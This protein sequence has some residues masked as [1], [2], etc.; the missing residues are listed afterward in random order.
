MKPKAAQITPC[1]LLAELS[2]PSVTQPF[3]D[4]C[5]APMSFITAISVQQIHHDDKSVS[6]YLIIQSYLILT[7]LA[8]TVAQGKVVMIYNNNLQIHRMTRSQKVPSVTRQ[9]LA[10]KCLLLI[11]QLQ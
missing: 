9:A 7:L 1:H 5:T 6:C 11:C 4:I 2:M 3:I 8:Y 10:L